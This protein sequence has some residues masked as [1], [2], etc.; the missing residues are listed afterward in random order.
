MGLPG[1]R[2]GTEVPAYY[3]H[4]H[5]YVQLKALLGDALVAEPSNLI[6]D[7]KLVKS[8]AELA[9]IRR[10]PGIADAAMEVPGATLAEGRTE[11]YCPG[12]V[13]HARLSAGHGKTGR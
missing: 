3:L 12:T 9:Y 6:H 1:A 7:M 8:P 2:V 13:S 10:P 5:H 11:L 4:P